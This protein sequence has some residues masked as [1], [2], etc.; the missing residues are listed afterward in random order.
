MTISVALIAGEG[1]SEMWL[2]IK[3]LNNYFVNCSVTVII[4]KL[5]HTSVKTNI[6]HTR[7]IEQNGSTTQHKSTMSI[8]CNATARIHN[9][10]VMNHY[11]GCCLI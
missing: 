9:D 10:S 8:L 3:Q 4:C 1:V 7:S 5:A 6:V 11:S 2:S